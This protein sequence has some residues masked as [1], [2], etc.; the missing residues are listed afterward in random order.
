MY[1]FNPLF[2]SGMISVCIN[3]KYAVLENKKTLE[4]CAVERQSP[5]AH[6][7]A[8][9]KT[10]TL[11]KKTR[12]TF[13]LQGIPSYQDFNINSRFKFINGKKRLKKASRFGSF[14][15]FYGV[16]TCFSF[17]SIEFGL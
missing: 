1:S 7:P 16:V 14:A 15:Q 6:H 11:Y 3:T 5:C 2:R 4:T 9:I 17:F 8:I 10:K 12:I 13:V